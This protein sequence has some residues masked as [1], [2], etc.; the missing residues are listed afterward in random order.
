[1]HLVLYLA[2]G[3]SGTNTLILLLAYLW[4]SSV[5]LFGG[6]TGYDLRPDGVSFTLSLL[7]TVLLVW[8]ALILRRRS[9]SE[10]KASALRQ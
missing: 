10:R 8:Y 1:M 7:T 4:D 3:L 9:R 6:A 5:T 2:T